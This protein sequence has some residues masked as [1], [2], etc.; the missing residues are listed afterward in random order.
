MYDNVRCRICGK[1]ISFEI[2]P[3]TIFSD[4]PHFGY[5]VPGIL[6]T[7]CTSVIEP[8]EEVFCDLIST[9]KDPLNRASEIYTVEQ[10]KLIME[11]ERADE[12][13]ENS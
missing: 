8:T 3:R 10:R 13:T 12:S 6:H 4:V 7:S 2:A 5:E 1:I 9:S 11:K